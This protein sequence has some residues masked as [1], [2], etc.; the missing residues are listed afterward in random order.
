MTVFKDSD[1]DLIFLSGSS[2]GRKIEFEGS[3]SVWVKDD[4]S[5]SYWNPIRSHIDCLDLV[6][7]HGILARFDGKMAR[8]ES[9]GISIGHAFN[10]DLYAGCAD[11][12]LRKCVAS[13]SAQIHLKTLDRGEISD[14]MA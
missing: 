10:C 13:V 1:E 4:G 5:R 12:C 3:Q 11:E 2:I 7:F 14:E 6:S 9:F 8:A